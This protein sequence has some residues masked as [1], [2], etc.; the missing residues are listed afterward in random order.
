[1]VNRESFKMTIERPLMTYIRDAASDSVRV[2]RDI[3][4]RLSKVIGR[5]VQI[6]TTKDLAHVYTD[7][8][9]H[10]IIQY[11]RATL[12]RVEQSNNGNKRE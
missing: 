10:G 5:T 8:I 3:E 1:M 7:L 6:R 4:M 2:P 11:L 12:A 9:R